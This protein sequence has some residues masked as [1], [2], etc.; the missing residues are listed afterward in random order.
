MLLGWLAKAAFVQK[1]DRQPDTS[2][3]G[4]EVRWV[5]GQQTVWVHAKDWNCP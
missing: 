4:E 1:F 5:G 2:R 3:A